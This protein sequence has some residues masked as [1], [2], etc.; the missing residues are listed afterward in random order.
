[1]RDTESRASP[2]RGAADRGAVRV[3]YAGR[4]Y[5]QQ[6]DGG[7]PYV[8]DPRYSLRELPDRIGGVVK[9]KPYRVQ[10]SCAGSSLSI[11][12]AI[13]IHE[14]QHGG[15]CDTR[16]VQVSCEATD[17]W[18]TMMAT[19]NI[20]SAQRNLPDSSPVK[21]LADSLHVIPT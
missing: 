5:G 6:P 3:R 17:A 14:Q 21:F 7:G 1:M 13:E 11:Q 18:S 10:L 12:A 20:L 15:Y 2:L 9:P 19:W 4:V 16:T 8:H